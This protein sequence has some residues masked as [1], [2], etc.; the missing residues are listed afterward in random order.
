[1]GQGATNWRCSAAFDQSFEN[2]H[3]LSR[4][5]MQTLHSLQTAALYYKLNN[6]NDFAQFIQ[7]LCVVCVCNHVQLCVLLLLLSHSLPHFNFPFCFSPIFPTGSLLGSDQRGLHSPASQWPSNWPDDSAHLGGLHC[8]LTGAHLR[9]A[10]PWLSGAH[11][12]TTVPYL[13]RCY[14][15]N[16]RNLCQL[17]RST[18]SHSPPLLA[19]LPGRSFPALLTIMA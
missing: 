13:A 7:W 10:W 12:P 16:F 9:L 2:S 1:M 19:H 18:S 6:N 11:R 5:V 17:L 4:I 14:L 15:P 3:S 8:H